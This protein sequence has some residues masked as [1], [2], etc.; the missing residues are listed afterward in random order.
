MRNPI[1]LL[2]PHGGSRIPGVNDQETI[3]LYPMVESPTAK[4]Q[5][6]LYSWPGKEKITTAGT[7]PGRCDPYEWKGDI[8]FISGDTLYKM[9][10]SDVVTAIGTL[11]TSTGWCVLA[12]GRTHLG[13]V[14]GTNGY[15]TDGSTLTQIGDADFPNGATHISYL[16]SYF[17]CADV[18][19]DQFFIS[20]S[21]DITSWNALDFASAESNPD[22][23]EA[24]IA[25]ESTLYLFG[26]KTIQPF[27]TVPNADFPF[28][29]YPN[30]IEY[31]IQAKYSLVRD[32]MGIYFLAKKPGGGIVVV[33]LSGI[34]G[35][36]L[37]SP[38]MT[39]EL[40]QLTTTS[41]AIGS[42]YDMK[43][44]PFYIL[45]FPSESLTFAFN[46][47]NGL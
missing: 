31:G 13:I 25:N 38:E 21:E 34:S 16:D 43:G 35:G 3:N 41:D 44:V 6:V 19:T 36:P 9:D 27:Q 7:G 46:T 47:V 22:D 40:N 23:I 11:N 18:D 26:G 20:A 42:L 33:R 8:Y 4:S 10:T 45:S 15:Y 28:D 24:H 32:E 1:P 2:G 30:V 29:A 14:D 12:G 39:W 37:S 5:L 17:I